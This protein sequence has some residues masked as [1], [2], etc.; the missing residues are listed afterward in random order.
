MIVIELAGI[1]QGKGRPRFMR[2]TGHAYTP[3]KTRNY[4]TNLRLAAQ[5]AM[6]GANP[7]EGPLAVTVRALFPV[8][9]SW[10][11][12]KQTAALEG[13]VRPTGRPDADNLMKVLDGLNEIVFRDDKQIV[14]GRVIKT[15]SA[16]PALRIEVVEISA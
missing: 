5:D 13:S 14:D 4:E 11:R 16:R 1:P 12:K 6:H 3:E 10:S 8:P 7:I 2:K 15:Y 9:T